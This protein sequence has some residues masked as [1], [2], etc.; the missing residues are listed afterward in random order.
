MYGRY[1]KDLGE[2]A[3]EEAKKLKA[4]EKKRKKE[5]KLREKDLQ[6]YRG[7]GITK[8]LSVVSFIWRNTFA[9]LGEDWV[10]LALLGIIM[11]LLSFLMDHGISMCNKGKVLALLLL[12]L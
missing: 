1:T 2:Y 7:E 8:I 11:A 5:E 9:R 4:L 12:L 6:K 10:F 3:K